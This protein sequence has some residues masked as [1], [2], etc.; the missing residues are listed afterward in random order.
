MA[1]QNLAVNQISA[2]VA[3]SSSVSSQQV[4]PGTA[5]TSATRSRHLLS[6]LRLVTR[7]SS[8]LRIPAIVIIFAMIVHKVLDTACPQ[9][10]TELK[11]A[12]LRQGPMT[13]L[14]SLIESI[15]GLGSKKADGE[16][17]TA[18]GAQKKSPE[19]N[20]GT[21]LRRRKSVD[22]A[23]AL[24][25]RLTPPIV[26]QTISILESVSPS[27]LSRSP[28]KSKQ[29]QSRYDNP[30]AYTATSSGVRA[31]RSSMT[32]GSG[33]Q[34][35][36]MGHVESVYP[37]E[38]QQGRTSITSVEDAA[39]YTFNEDSCVSLAATVQS[40][41]DSSSVEDLD[42]EASVSSLDQD[43]ESILEQQDEDEIDIIDALKA[44]ILE[45][46][47]GSFDDDATQV[48]TLSAS[49]VTAVLQCESTQAGVEATD[50]Q[51]VESVI[52]KTPEKDDEDTSMGVGR[53]F[54]M[55]D[56]YEHNVEDL[57]TAFDAAP[58]D[59]GECADSERDDEDIM[60]LDVATTGKRFSSKESA[61]SVN[62]NVPPGDD[63]SSSCATSNVPSATASRST[64]KSKGL[65]H[66]N[67]HGE[68]AEQVCPYTIFNNNTTTT[69]FSNTS[70]RTSH[71]SDNNSPLYPNVG[72][73]R[74]AGFA[75]RKDKILIID[76]IKAH[77]E[78]AD[79]SCELNPLGNVSLEDRLAAAARPLSPKGDD[80]E[81]DHADG[82][83]KAAAT[84]LD[85]DEEE[86]VRNAPVNF[87]DPN[88]GNF[89][90][91]FTQLLDV[92]YRD[93]VTPYTAGAR[94]RGMLAG[95]LEGAVEKAAQP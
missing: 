54:R 49:V 6:F 90:L 35:M 74:P 1:S 80:E 78:E 29:N 23:Y 41:E 75:V 37:A 85:D 4:F 9:R 15:C 19:E 20:E 73:E 17:S 77:D 67:D 66:Q 62:T 86:A 84:Y 5:G 76:E 34:L 89:G 52:D 50:I 39:V 28:E 43:Q 25:D 14:F 21:P 93:Q 61:G 38:A 92:K 59:D 36:N 87:L 40:V 33:E 22:V 71:N 46:A 47:E 8:Y 83:D 69:G 72:G 13:F 94:E 32:L 44:E 79:E 55:S 26:K 10:A 57:S 27:K 7:L 63:G 2:G 16:A 24:A 82:E 95:A 70:A 3:L 51:Q 30:D 60:D 64:T 81:G 18:E 42:R 12:V 53:P 88:V 45:Q 58:V 68:M 48:E 31:P 91:W 56:Y 11:N 65:H